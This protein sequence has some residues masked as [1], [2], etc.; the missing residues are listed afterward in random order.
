MLLAPMTEQEDFMN[1]IASL[2]TDNGN[3]LHRDMSF[4]P[5]LSALRN[6]AWFSAYPQ[7]ALTTLSMSASL[8]SFSARQQ[9]VLEGRWLGAAVLV[10]KGCLRAVRRTDNAR[11]LTLE[12]FRPGD[13]I[14]DAVISAD[15]TVPG[16]GLVAA[17]TSLLLFIPREDFLSALASVPQAALSLIRDLERRL[18]RVK[19][20]A[21][22]LATS[23][24]ESRL[25]RLLFN[26]ARDEGQVAGEST[27]IPRSP[28]QQDLASR[29]GAC[30]ETVSRIVADL[31]RQ[32]VLTLEGR[33][34]TLA[35]RF[36]EIARSAG[37]A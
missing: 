11:E 29:I 12:T 7:N 23:D 16:D 1:A 31:A 35:P 17:E 18:N 8:T 26:L 10:V 3:P 2:R 30:R 34:L 21:S 28:T 25:Y 4:H 14:A 6:S 13:L 9:V 22:G 27:V 32:Q 36:F 15:G 33:K 5:A 24:V 20:L 37:I 19:L